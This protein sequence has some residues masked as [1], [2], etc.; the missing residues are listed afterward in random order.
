[1]SEFG[2]PVNVWHYMI[3]PFDGS[4]PLC[5]THRSG[6]GVTM[7]ES[8]VTCPECL[9]QMSGTVA[10]ASR[11]RTAALQARAEAEWRRRDPASAALYDSMK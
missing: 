2:A 9:A 5:G 8:D 1:M 11:E 7:G 4:L 10:Q 3:D 6:E